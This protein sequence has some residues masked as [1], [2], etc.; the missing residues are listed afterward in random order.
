MRNRPQIRPILPFNYLI[1]YDGSSF[2]ALNGYK[3]NIEKKSSDASTVIQ[4]IINEVSG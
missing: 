3:L 1:F 2:K 4:E